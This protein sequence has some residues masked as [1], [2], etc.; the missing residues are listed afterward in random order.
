MITLYEKEN[1]RLAFCKWK[2]NAEPY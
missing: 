1:K 2:W